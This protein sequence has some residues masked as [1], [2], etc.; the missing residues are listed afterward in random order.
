MSR[1]IGPGGSPGSALRTAVTAVGIGALA[2]LAGTLAMTVSST[3]EARIRGRAPSTT[4][5]KALGNTLGVEPRNDRARVRLDN[6]AHWGY[7][8]TL[9]SLRGLL[10]ALGVSGPAAAGVHLGVIYAAEQ[11]VLPATG[12]ATPAWTWAGKETGID[13]VHHAVYAAVTSVAYDLLSE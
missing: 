6:V 4:P 5:G 12:A 10:G 3:L 1:H 11:V 2:G 13:L 8:T 9:G 7:G